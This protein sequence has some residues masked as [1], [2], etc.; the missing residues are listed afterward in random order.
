MT[1]RPRIL[2]VENVQLFVPREIVEALD[3]FY[4]DRIGFERHKKLN[5]D[6]SLEYRGRLRS[7]PR[8]ILN[9]LPPDATVPI[10][11]PPLSIEIAN[12]TEFVERIEQ[13]KMDYA[14]VRGW[15]F[16]DRKLVVHD[17]AGHRL[18]LG[19]SHLF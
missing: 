12:L 7:G 1:Y 4:A 19:T 18:E 5:G 16:Y 9:V 17:P 11:R 10:S 14:W 2:A 15:S 13:E 6:N 8:L 3:Q